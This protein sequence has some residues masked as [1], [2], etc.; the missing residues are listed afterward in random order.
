MIIIAITI[1]SKNPIWRVFPDFVTFAEGYLMPV[2]AVAYQG[3][4]LG[5]AG[6]GARK[7][8]A[9]NFLATPTNLLVFS[10]F[11]GPRTLGRSA[12]RH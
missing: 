1:F 12:L 7:L 6:I 9:K 4:E 8:R 2:T 11:D 5:G 10:K 3:F